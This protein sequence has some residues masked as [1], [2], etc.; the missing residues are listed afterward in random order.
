MGLLHYEWFISACKL[1]IT[2]V[3][4]KADSDLLVESRNSDDSLWWTAE[5]YLPRQTDK[6]VL[7]KQRLISDTWD[8]EVRE[9]WPLQ[10]TGNTG[11]IDVCLKKKKMCLCGWAH[12]HSSTYVLISWRLCSWPAACSSTEWTHLGF[13]KRTHQFSKPTTTH[14]ATASTHPHTHTHTPNL[15]C[16]TPG[17]SNRSLKVRVKGQEG[18]GVGGEIT[19]VPHGYLNM[20]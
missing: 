15:C 11:K 10:V 5:Q 20:S 3:I 12:P 19:V 6:L 14:K 2:P 17:D 7:S 4:C 13:L 8:Y 18:R 1:C 16:G 9:L